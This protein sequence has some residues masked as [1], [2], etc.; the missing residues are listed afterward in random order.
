MSLRDVAAGS[1]PAAVLELYSAAGVGRS[2]EVSCRAAGKPVFRVSA[3]RRSF[4]L[5]AE[6][7]IAGVASFEKGDS[8]RAGPGL[9][10]LYIANVFLKR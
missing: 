10:D 3:G 4:A 8:G 1:P 6:V 9:G 2:P 7:V 5:D